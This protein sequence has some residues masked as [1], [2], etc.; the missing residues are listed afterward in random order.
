[1][2]VTSCKGLDVNSEIR[3]ASCK[4]ESAEN[5]V[6]M[7]CGTGDAI[8]TGYGDPKLTRRPMELI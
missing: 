8:G 3:G 4:S 7:N 2:F 5:C 1:M 6:G